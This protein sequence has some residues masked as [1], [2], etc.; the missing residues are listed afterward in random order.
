MISVL[1]TWIALEDLATNAQKQ[2]RAGVKSQAPGAFLP[3]HAS[4]A[5]ALA[6]ARAQLTSVFWELR[7]IAKKE[8]ELS[9]WREVE[10][11]LGV[12]AFGPPIPLPKWLH[13]VRAISVGSVAVPP[14]LTPT[15]TQSEAAAFLWALGSRLGP[16]TRFRIEELSR[17]LRNGGE[18]GNWVGEIRMLA[19]LHLAR[20]RFLRHATVH[21]ARHSDDA[22]RQLAVASHDIAD[23]VYEVLPLWLTGTNSTWEGLR[24]ARGHLQNLLAAWTSSSGHPEID[25][26]RILHP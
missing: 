8:G 6:C 2:T 17:R 14:A 26:D 12:K 5:V 15:A 11:W 9:A 21:R 19:E 4:A 24:D 20:M 23:A 25:P 7:I 16:Y 3:P 13:L 18:L 1:H 10:R 22:A